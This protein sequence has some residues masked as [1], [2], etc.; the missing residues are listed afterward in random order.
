MTV[1]AH[2]LLPVNDAPGANKITRVRS[3]NL[4][5][6]QEISYV[7]SALFMSQDL[8][9]IA[10][11]GI[12]EGEGGVKLQKKTVCHNRKGVQ[13]SALS[14][15]EVRLSD[16]TVIERNSWGRLVV[17]YMVVFSLPFVFTDLF[18]CFVCYGSTKRSVCLFHQSVSYVLQFNLL[19]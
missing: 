2:G 5:P 11:L 18:L 16:E 17:Y 4:S 9:Q 12:G 10:H 15:Q 7:I 13:L 19:E 6:S 1:P 3:K 14:K 8:F